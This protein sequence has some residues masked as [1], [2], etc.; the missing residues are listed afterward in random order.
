MHPRAQDN[1]E[2][3][4]LR[5]S[6]K[7]HTQAHMRARK[8]T[9]VFS[10][11]K[12]HTCVSIHA[13]TSE[14]GILIASLTRSPLT[15]PSTP[16]LLSPSSTSLVTSA[17]AIRGATSAN[18][19]KERGGRED[20]HGGGNEE[21]K[22]CG[23]VGEHTSLGQASRGRERRVLRPQPILVPSRGAQDDVC[24]CPCENV[25]RGSARRRPAET[26]KREKQINRKKNRWGRRFNVERR[27]AC[28]R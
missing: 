27:P 3:D 7:M 2:Q 9:F 17:R 12:R 26:G 8:R 21:G 4:Q 23:W 28:R 20:R 24:A 15:Y 22:R 6:S 19:R 1:N 25:Q 10:P 16:F 13:T 11:L 14:R 18:T 5:C